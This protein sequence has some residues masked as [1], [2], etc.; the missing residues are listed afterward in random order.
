MIFGMNGVAV[1]RN[2][3]KLWENGAGR[4]RKAMGHLPE[5]WDSI[6]KIKNDQKSKKMKN[7]K[8]SEI[9]K[10][11]KSVFSPLVRATLG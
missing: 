8:K 9:S 2:G 3:L 10:I 6:N 7:G 1:A 11:Q 5:P 4:S